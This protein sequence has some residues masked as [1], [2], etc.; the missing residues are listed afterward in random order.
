M[1]ETISATSANITHQDSQDY[2]HVWLSLPATPIARDGVLYVAEVAMVT[3]TP[4]GY[5]AVTVLEDD[6]HTIPG[7]VGVGMRDDIEHAAIEALR[8]ML[9]VDLADVV[10]DREWLALA[11]V[12]GVVKV[13]A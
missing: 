9:D 13:A 7:R 3:F 6:H 8:D 1:S 2:Y 11:D 5:A 10:R 12:A 4:E